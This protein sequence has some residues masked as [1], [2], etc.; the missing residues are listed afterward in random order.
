V[1][2]IRANAELALQQLSFQQGLG[3]NRTLSGSLEDLRALTLLVGEEAVTA[4]QAAV[5]AEEEEVTA[6]LALKGG[7][8]A[9]ATARLTLAALTDDTTIGAQLRLD[10]EAKANGPIELEI[11]TF[12]SGLWV[13]IYDV[14][15]TCQG[16]A[17]LAIKR[18]VIIAQESGEDW[19]G[20]DLT[21][22]TAQL[23]Q[24]ADPCRF[25]P[26]HRGIISK[27]D[28]EKFRCRERRRRRQCWNGGATYRACRRSKLFPGLFL[29]L[30]G[31]DNNLS[32]PAPC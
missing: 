25:S 12:R 26:D 31:L 24:Q 27:V 2:G 5:S 8:E 18:G 11:S 21:I 22:S 30:S 15:L 1:E 14:Y 9:L 16:G 19:R 32:F 29:E 23:S 3:Q 17:A 6:D 13:P 7:R 10:L 4:R 28:L 20:V